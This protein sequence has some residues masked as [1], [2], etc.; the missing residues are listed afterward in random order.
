MRN[1]EIPFFFLVIIIEFTHYYRRSFH[2]RRLLRSDDL[3]KRDDSILSHCLGKF[4]SWIIEDNIWE[5][6]AFFNIFRIFSHLIKVLKLS[7]RRT[8]CIF[9]KFGS[10]IDFAKS[11]EVRVISLKLRK[12]HKV[13]FFSWNSFIL[14]HLYENLSHFK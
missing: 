12:V 2:L 10:N 3:R 13:K 7:F 11:F 9:I 4:I 6:L 1:H 8:E 14:N 5:N